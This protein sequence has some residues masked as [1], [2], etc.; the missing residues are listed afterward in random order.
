M[1]EGF[2][3]RANQWPE[4]NNRGRGLYVFF[5]QSVLRVY[6]DLHLKSND[7]KKKKKCGGWW[8]NSFVL[9][10]PQT[11][12]EV[13]LVRAVIIG[14]RDY[15]GERSRLFILLISVKVVITQCLTATVR[16]GSSTFGDLGKIQIWTPQIPHPVNHNTPQTSQ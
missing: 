12:R 10:L 5:D 7:Q 4:R 3:K 15:S 13:L 1:R 11:G 6:Y 2:L 14:C 16:A 9:N 8:P